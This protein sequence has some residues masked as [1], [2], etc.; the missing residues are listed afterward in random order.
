MSRSK[1]LQAALLAAVLSAGVP[2]LAATVSPFTEQAFTASQGEGKPILVHI[3]ATWCPTC[4]KQHPILAQLENDPAFKS[5]VV[6]NVDFDTQKDVVRTMG[7][8]MQSTLIAFHGTTE[9]GRSTGD[10]NPDSIKALLEK[11]EK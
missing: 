10:T 5:L 11:A 6:Y 3:T 8:Q 4:A 7:A 2:A 1:L 9:A